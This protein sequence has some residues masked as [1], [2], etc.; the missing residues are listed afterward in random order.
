MINLKLACR[1]LFKTPF[2]TIIAIASL[3]LGIGANAAIFSLFNQML[4][5]PLPVPEP[6]RLVNIGSPGPRQGSASCGNAGDCDVVFTYPMFRD[7]ERAQT[8]FT[9][10][11]AHVLFG[12]NL[13]FGGQTLSGEGELVSGSYF[14][15]LGVQ[16]AL[17]RLLGQQDDQTIGEST[18]VVL[19]HAYWQTRFAASPT[20]LDAKMIVNGQP[21]TIVGVAPRGFAG[22][23]LGSK[24]EVFVP[25]TLRGLMQPN[26]KGF[27]DRK[28][29]WAYLFA[30]L[31]PGMSIEQARAAINVPYRTLINDIDAPL[32]KMSEQ[33]LARFK[34]KQITLEDGS[35]GQSTVAGEAKGPLTLLLGVTALVLLIACANIANLLVVRAAARAGEMAIRLSLGASRWQLVAQLL[36]E[37]CVL[38][39]FGGA[40]GLL[41]ARWTLQLIGSL[42]P[43]QAATMIALQIDLPVLIFAAALTIGTGLLFGLFPALH[44][45]RP[46]LVS[47]LKGQAGQPSGTRTAARFR[48]SLATTQ[49]ALSMALLV[50]AGLFTKSL[51]NV[52][53][54][55]LGL[56]IDHVVTFA[57]SPD[58][59]GYKP[60]RA[61]ALFERLEQELAALPGVTAVSESRI[62]L[63]AGDNWGSSVSVEGFKADSDTD[64]HAMYNMISSGYFRTLGIPMLAGRDFTVADAGSAPKVAVVNEAFAKKFNLGHDAVGKRMNSGRG[65][66]LDTEIVGLVQNAKYSQVKDEIPPVF[67]RPYRQDPE[68]GAINF[69]VRVA[70]ESASI[71]S[72]IPKVVAGL[73]PNLP[74]ENLRTLPDEVRENVFL[75]RFITVLSTAFAVLATLLAAVGLY[76]VLAYTVAQRTREI[77]LRIALGATPSRVRGMILRQVGRMTLIGGTIGLLAASGLGRL[78]ESLLYRLKGWDPVVLVGSAIALTLVA[79][80]AGFVPAQR[81]SRVDPMRALRYE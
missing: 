4:L 15:V 53:R 7:L 69:Y 60:A 28:S 43:P 35:R 31:K 61:Q 36:A 39:V 26:F 50:S 55:D 64:T 80:S 34:A 44:S 79:L 46:D 68:V 54:V 16:P 71:L 41:V 33:T 66:G 1:T 23:T 32:Q 74:V 38:A 58:L 81:A 8:V 9:G 18:V 73:D 75:D 5:R 24:P 27:D 57:V 63:L 72:A 56:N 2:V 62:R 45:T 12:A 6:A 29:Y 47:A 48:A 40:A 3:A 22:T 13:S 49:I 37:S 21:M 59:S 10:L 17:G 42:L 14:P 19:S 52:S 20:V 51:M 76:G 70:G 77:G 25:I 11:A 30:R 67:F 78:A 65:G